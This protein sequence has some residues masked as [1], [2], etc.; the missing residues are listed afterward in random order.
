MRSPDRRC[1][2]HAVRG[3]QALA[4][5][6][7]Q[8]QKRDHD[9]DECRHHHPGRVLEKANVEQAGHDDVD[10]VADDQWTDQVRDVEHRKVERNLAGDG[11]GGILNLFDEIEHQRGE[12]QDRGVVREEGAREGAGKKERG[13]EFA[14]V[15]V[16]PG[17]DA[18]G[19]QAKQ[20]GLRGHQGHGHQAD[21]RDDGNAQQVEDL[22]D[23]SRGD[24]PQNQGQAGPDDCR[25]GRL[26][27]ETAQH[28]AAQRKANGDGK[29][30]ERGGTLHSDGPQA[31]SWIA[32]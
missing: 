15:P 5:E 4:K 21:E 9:A 12:D 27:L 7:T 24:E 1:R 13:E 3:R 10:G 17:G 22:G 23:L 18:C 11:P 26:N 29:N 8:A 32:R 30:R 25:D 6:E 28:R 31:M 14:R 16:G 2:W 20:P 19:Q